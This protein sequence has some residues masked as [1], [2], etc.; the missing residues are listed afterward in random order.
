M[1]SPEPYTFLSEILN[2]LK[3]ENQK[4]LITQNE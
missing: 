4:A 1:N 3:E 2:I